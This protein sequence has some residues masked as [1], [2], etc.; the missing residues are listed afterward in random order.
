MKRKQ[1]HGDISMAY[2]SFLFCNYRRISHQISLKKL[3][4]IQPVFQNP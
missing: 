1:A 3:S 2:V 4:T